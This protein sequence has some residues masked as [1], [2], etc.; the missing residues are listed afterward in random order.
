MYQIMKEKNKIILTG[1]LDSTDYSELKN[2]IFNIVYS[3]DIIKK[4]EVDISGLMFMNSSAFKIII[5]LFLKCEEENTEC[6]LIINPNLVW[7]RMN[8]KNLK[9]LKKTKVKESNE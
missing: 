4:V 7:Q 3:P 6:A 2:Q 8:A 9:F 5:D 1:E